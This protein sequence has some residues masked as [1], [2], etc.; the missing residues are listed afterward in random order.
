M[1]FGAQGGVIYNIESGQDTPFGIEDNVYVSDHRKFLTAR[2]MSHSFADD[3]LVRN[4]A[5]PLIFTDDELQNSFES[6]ED[7]LYG[8]EEEHEEVEEAREGK[9][10]TLPK[11]LLQSK[12]EFTV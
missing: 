11:G 2:M 5:S 10:R 6:R 12:C 7:G 1:L 4:P 3:S 8:Q 9:T